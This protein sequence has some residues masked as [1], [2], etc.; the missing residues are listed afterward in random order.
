MI[1]S[2]DTLRQANQSFNILFSK[3]AAEA[4]PVYPLLAMIVPSS[5]TLVRYPMWN[6]LPGMREWLGERK[7]QN[8]QPS[9]YAIVN[10]NYEET[11][12]VDRNDFDDDQLGIYA[13]LIQGMGNQALMHRDVLLYNL[14]AAAFSA[15]T[16]PC[17]D[18]KA[19]CATNH[20]LGSRTWSNKGTA[21]LS[22]TAVGVAIAKLFSAFDDKNQLFSIPSKMKLCVAPSLIATAW[23]I[24]KAKVV[25]GDST[26]G[27]SKDNAYQGILEPVIIPTLELHPTYWFVIAEYAGMKPIIMQIRKEPEFVA[28]DNPEDP[29]VFNN[30]VYTYGVD[31]RKNV[32]WGPYTLIYGSTGGA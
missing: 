26:A 31:D 4:K 22:P 20:T 5:G 28:N 1:I 12:S 32:G 16:Y 13:P 17:F 23:E 11:I 29:N 10:K 25:L 27:G 15:T 2:S 3:G 9:D 8:L 21:V 14:L 6:K 30:R 24:C 18:G 7:H 19:M